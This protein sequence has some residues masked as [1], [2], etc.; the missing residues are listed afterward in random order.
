[1]RRNGGT[2]AAESVRQGILAIVVQRLGV[3]RSLAVGSLLEKPLFDVRPADMPTYAVVC[4][5]LGTGGILAG[6]LPA[7]IASR[8]DPASGCRSIEAG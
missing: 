8:M 4:G 6:Y 7:R 2:V 5:V 1:M 3:L